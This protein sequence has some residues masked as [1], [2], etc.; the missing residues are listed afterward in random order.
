MVRRTGEEVSDLFDEPAQLLV[1]V[2]H[3]LLGLIGLLQHL[4]S[5][6][7]GFICFY[8]CF[9]HLN[10]QQQVNY[11]LNKLLSSNRCDCY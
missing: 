5:I 4:L 2:I 1:A 8:F 9:R 6:Q 7:L 11:K 10:I 3:T